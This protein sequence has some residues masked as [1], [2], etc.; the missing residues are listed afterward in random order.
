MKLTTLHVEIRSEQ[1]QAGQGKTS[2][3]HSDTLVKE[4]PVKVPSSACTRRADEICADG[5]SSSN[6]VRTNS[7]EEAAA[8]A[9]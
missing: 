2:S 6:L 5:F 7:G 8:A 1:S 4:K 9:L 3:E